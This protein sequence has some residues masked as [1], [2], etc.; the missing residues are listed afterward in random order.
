[1]TRTRVGLGGAD[2]GAVARGRAFYTANCLAC[3]GPAGKGDGPIGASLDPRPRDF[4][5]DELRFDTDGDGRSGTDADL[6]NVITRGAI[7]YGGSPLMA[8]WA[9]L[10]R[11]Q[12]RDVIAYLRTLAHRAAAKRR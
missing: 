6:A 10:S 7:A 12:A 8:S 3:H 5:R 9:H 2:G 11:D 1:M 4:S